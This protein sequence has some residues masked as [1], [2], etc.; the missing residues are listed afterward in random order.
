MIPT[1]QD[2][3]GDIHWAEQLIALTFMFLAGVALGW[4]IW[5]AP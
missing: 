4:V 3:S 1:E 2:V 5:K